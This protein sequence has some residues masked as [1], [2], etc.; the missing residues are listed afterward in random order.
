MKKKLENRVAVVTGASSGIGRATA[1]ALAARGASVVVVARRAEVLEEVVDECRAHGVEAL[2]MPADV[3][4]ADAMAT[5][6]RETAGRFGRIDIWVNNAAVSM[7]GAVDEGPVEHW[8]RVIETNVF[9]TYHG[10]RAVL[11]WMREQAGGVII[12]VSS[13]LGKYGAPYLSAYVASKHSVR[14][15]SDC[16][17]QE[18]F[19][20][21]DVHVCTVLPGPIDT[22]FFQHSAN[23]SGREIKPIKPV[24]DAHRVAHAIVSVC[25]RPRR[26]AVVGGSSRQSLL[27]A[28]LAP[29]LLE[30]IVSRKIDSDHFADRPAP[31]SDGNLFE[32]DPGGDQVTGGWARSGKHVG[33]GGRRAASANGHHGSAWKKAAAVGAAAAAATT[34]VRRRSG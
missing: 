14:A 3:T 9:G 5:V 23:F 17:R 6:A 26:E 31:P 22:P 4:D 18:L 20:L 19:D 33:E 29:G 15:L 21:D 2:A 10:V 8:H 11:P 34:V 30:R 7:F 12:N 13:V 25:T 16:V 28:R 1:V 24:I 27:L 32:P